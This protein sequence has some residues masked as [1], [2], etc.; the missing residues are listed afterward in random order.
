MVPLD[1]ISSILLQMLITFTLFLSRVK[2]KWK[3]IGSKGKNPLTLL[4][5]YT[6]SITQTEYF[7]KRVHR[8]RKGQDHS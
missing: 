3:R 2:E 1:K 5:L 6:S 7:R 4:T 8:L